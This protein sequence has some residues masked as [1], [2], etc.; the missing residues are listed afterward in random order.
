MLNQN[1][2]LVKVENL[3]VTFP[4]RT[5]LLRRVTGCV[6]AV[7]DVSFEIAPGKTLALAGESGCGKTTL[8][9]A[10]LRLIPA[11]A[12]RVYFNGDDIIQYPPRKMRKLRRDMQIIFQN[13]YASLNPRMNVADIVGEPLAVHNLARRRRKR[14]AVAALLKNVGLTADHMNRYP[15]EFSGGQ[16]QR[17]AIARALATGPKFVV[18]DEPL[19]SLDVSI[20]SRIINLLRSLQREFAITYLFITHDLAIVPYISD[21]VAVM[22]MGRIVEYGPPHRLCTNPAHP[23]TKALISAVP[24]P[25]PRT[26]PVPIYLPADPPTAVTPP[27]GCRFHPR[28]PLA[29]QRCTR[30]T[31]TLSRTKEDPA[32]LVACWKCRQD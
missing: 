32:Q 23:Y 18:C 29:D 22:Y 11:T 3:K 4:I 15:H 1:K 8:A 26:K 28:C 16:R 17:I 10:V 9:K 5:N 19:S 2:H 7:D 20:K 14:Q 31:P 12:G 30:D 24:Q 27:T 6:R 25:N 21:H 13:P